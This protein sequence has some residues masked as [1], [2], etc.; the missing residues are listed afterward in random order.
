LQSHA[1]LLGTSRPTLYHVLLD[2]NGFTSDILQKV[3]YN[4]CHVYARCAKSVSLVPPVYYAHLLAFRARHYQN[5]LPET[6]GG[7]RDEPGLETLEAM[8]N[9]MYFV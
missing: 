7:S 6:R 5:E 4:L 3:T 8:K 2:E 9:L 1:G